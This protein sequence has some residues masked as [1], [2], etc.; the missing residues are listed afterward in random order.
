MLLVSTIIVRANFTLFMCV[1]QKLMVKDD[2]CLGR[3]AAAL[4][5]VLIV[6]VNDSF[7]VLA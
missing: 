5:L 4:I 1:V 2:A 7:V 6:D 3:M